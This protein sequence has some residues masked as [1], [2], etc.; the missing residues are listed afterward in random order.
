MQVFRCGLPAPGPH[1]IPLIAESGEIVIVAVP[2]QI[3]RADG[4]GLAVIFNDMLLLVIVI[5]IFERDLHAGVDRF[6]HHIDNVVSLFSDSFNLHV[7]W[8]FGNTRHFLQ[9]YH[10]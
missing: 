2:D 3:I 10:L 7:P 5:E 8:H 4:I 9:R 6:I 1:L